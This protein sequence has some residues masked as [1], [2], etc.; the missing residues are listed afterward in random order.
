MEMAYPDVLG[1]Y[2]GGGRRWEAFGVQ[3]QWRLRPAAVRPGDVAWLLL[4][5]QSEWDIPFVLQA[6][7]DLPQRR[8]KGGEDALIAAQPATEIP[9]DALE[10]GELRL[11]L[12]V[13]PRTPAGEYP[14]G[15]RLQGSA[16]GRGLRARPPRKSGKVDP[17]AFPF[18]EGLGLAQTLGVDYHTEVRQ[19][20]EGRL[21]VSEEA[22]AQEEVV[23]DLTPIFATY[24]TADDWPA[25]TAAQRELNSRRPY[26]L[27]D[28]TDQ[29][30]FPLLLDAARERFANL[31]MSLRIGELLMLTKT[32]LFTTQHFLSRPER[33]EGLLLPLLQTAR[34]AGLSTGEPQR[35]LC[36]LGLP[37][38]VRL[39]AALSFGLLRQ[40]F[41]R[42][43]WP[44][45]EQQAVA[46]LLA[47]RTAAPGPLG[48][49]FVYI[50]LFLGGL[51]V[52][53]AVT[54]PGEDPKQT[55]AL[56]RKA[57]IARGAELG[58]VPE[59]IPLLERLLVRDR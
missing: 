27:R 45:S 54:M 57:V 38:L 53:D 59:L 56:A 25:Q 21:R 46:E 29:T 39:A 8:V 55:L 36:S 50:P 4:P 23:A 22:E 26:L 14:F 5:M 33:H 13:H 19:T 3:Y 44:P 32:L 9:L 49:E 31:Q 2:V 6:I 51:I 47:S 37:R 10:V 24:W 11:P 28:L 17:R 35:L 48:I 30:L 7:L 16:G 52:S 43:P 15:L 41:G 34:T 58:V 20:V 1:D 18:V 40:R 42:D 12:R